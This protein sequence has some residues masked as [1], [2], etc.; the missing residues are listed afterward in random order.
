LLL[1]RHWVFWQ[2]LDPDFRVA[3][4]SAILVLLISGQLGEG[5]IESGLT[6]LLE[7][8]LGGAV[9]VITS[10]L[11]FPERAHRLAC[12]AGARVLDE[13]AGDVAEI[14]A[15][16]FRP[17]DR[18]QVLFL[19]DRIGHT[20]SDLQ[21]LVAEV[22][23]ERPVNFVVAPD[24]APLPRTLLRIRHDFVMVGRASS[25]Q[26]STRLSDYLIGVPPM[27]SAAG[28]GHPCR[29]GATRARRHR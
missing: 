15:G 11:V 24:P 21:G 27:S 29:P 19:Q 13:M 16:F 14:F 20:V 17:V 26:L 6:R 22:E 18:N 9:A 4:F 23:S 10:F 1:L 7:V 3:P 12:E 5:T 2:R 25:E 8:T 28:Q